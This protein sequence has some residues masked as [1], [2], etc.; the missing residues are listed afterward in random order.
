MITAEHE[1]KPSFAR[2]VRRMIDD[3]R[4]EAAF[5]LSADGV[6][7]F[8]T[9]IGGYVLLAECFSALG[10]FEDARVINE[11]IMR[12]WKIRRLEEEKTRGIEEEKTRGIEER[13]TEEVEKPILRDN[14]SIIMPPRVG[15]KDE[16]KKVV[17]KHDSPLR[18]IEFARPVDDTRQIRSSSVRLIPGLEYTSL[19]FEGAKHR[20]RRAI[21]ML[22]DPPAFR[23][24]HAPRKSPFPPEKTTQRKLSLEE[25]AERIG[26]VR[27]TAEDLEK[28]P[29]APDPVATPRRSV[30]SETLARIYMQQK[31]YD[32]AID[33]F[34]ALKEQKPDSA[35]KFQALIEECEALRNAAAS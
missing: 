23:E 14:S 8:P 30:V 27:I 6:R 31:S 17:V 18:I 33:A 1:V 15:L 5:A 28:R 21:Q 7:A 20:G 9:Y 32:K 12:K 16:K 11:E 34:S 19:R 22:S 29:A 13:K 3:G 25:I 26:K 24:F 2:D 4:L 35:E 10:H